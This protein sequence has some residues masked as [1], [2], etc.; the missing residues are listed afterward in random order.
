[1]PRLVHPEIPCLYEYTTAD[2]TSGWN[3]YK[4]S[5]TRQGHKYYRTF[6]LT[7]YGHPDLPLTKAHALIAALTYWTQAQQSIVNRQSPIPNSQSST[8]NS[9]SPCFATTIALPPA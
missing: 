4:V 7:R 9:Q 6:P 5:I 2:D 3:G 8:V 1:M